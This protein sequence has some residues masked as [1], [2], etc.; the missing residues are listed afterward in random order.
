VFNRQ[1][2]KGERR[3]L[4][5]PEIVE[6]AQYRFGMSIYRSKR[7]ELGDKI[8]REQRDWLAQWRTYLNQQYPGFPAKAQFNPGELDKFVG[9]LKRAVGDERLKDNDVAGAVRQYLEARDKAFAQAKVGGLSDLSSDRA[10]PLKDWLSSIANTL[11]QQT[12]EF[13]RIFEDKLAAE[14]D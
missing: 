2:K 7:A 11:I 1:I 5:A 6:V 12:P 9:D 10:Q 4:T 8:S 13:S 14:V 3:R